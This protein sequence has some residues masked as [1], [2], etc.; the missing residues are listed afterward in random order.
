M[1]LSVRMSPR[2]LVAA[3]SESP[4]VIGL[5]EQEWFIASDIPAFLPY[6]RKVIFLDDEEMA[7]VDQ[8]G[9]KLSTLS[10]K[11]VSKADPYN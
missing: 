4:L 5:G 7:V 9:V 8:N 1:V 3:R 10:G 6:T 2:T 11:K